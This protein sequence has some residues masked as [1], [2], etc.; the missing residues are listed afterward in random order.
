MRYFTIISIVLSLIFPQI[1]FSAEIYYKNVSQGPG[2]Q[3]LGKKQVPNENAMNTSCH[4]FQ[5][6]DSG[7]LI[8]VEYLNYGMLKESPVFHAASLHMLYRDDGRVEA[9]YFNTQ[10]IK[11][12][13]EIWDSSDMMIQTRRFGLDGKLCLGQDGWAVA[14]ASYDADGSLLQIMYLDTEGRFTNHNSQG[15]A[16]IRFDPLKETPN[17]ILTAEDTLSMELLEQLGSFPSHV[18]CV[19]IGMTIQDVE[20]CF[21]SDNKKLLVLDYRGEDGGIT[22]QYFLGACNNG[23][24]LRFNITICTYAKGDFVKSMKVTDG[25]V[26][27]DTRPRLKGIVL[28]ND[29]YSD[30]QL[31]LSDYE[32]L[33]SYIFSKTGLSA[34]EGK[35]SDPHCLKVLTMRLEGGMWSNEGPKV[36]IG[37]ARNSSVSSKYNVTFVFDYGDGTL[38]EERSVIFFP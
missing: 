15:C 4:R 6:D 17:E 22:G 28:K 38:S 33:K 23:F 8:L 2:P 16:V 32:L 13:D 12:A 1:S 21:E 14:K 30:L 29:Q 26:S 18:G 10:G 25:G 27:V 11:R 31:A 35:C 5:Y 7:Q 19:R 9:S 34:V 20:G 3:I 24:P 36:I 37:V